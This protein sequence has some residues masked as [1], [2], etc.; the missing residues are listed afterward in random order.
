MRAAQ[1]AGSAQQIRDLSHQIALGFIQST[2]YIGMGRTNGQYVEDLYDAVLRRAAAPSE[3]NY[4]LNYLGT[5]T[6]EQALQGFTDSNE[7]QTRVQ[8]VIDAGCL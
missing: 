8:A 2:E 6:R 4:W 7:F 3:V 5:A 1:C